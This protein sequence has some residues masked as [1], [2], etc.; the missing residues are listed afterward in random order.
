MVRDARQCRSASSIV[1]SYNCPATRFVI[2]SLYLRHDAWPSR[3][4]PTIVFS[5]VHKIPT[6]YLCWKMHIL[7]VRVIYIYMYNIYNLYMVYCFAFR[8][9]SYLKI[10]IYIYK[11]SPFIYTS[12]TLR[13]IAQHVAEWALFFSIYLYILLICTHKIIIIRRM[14][15]VLFFFS[16]LG[17]CSESGRFEQMWRCRVELRSRTSLYGLKRSPI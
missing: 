6:I 17:L 12:Y 7:L 10:S 16:C 13:N 14:F 8:A 9:R 5:F 15:R 11:Y 3:E 2:L 1:S 4:C